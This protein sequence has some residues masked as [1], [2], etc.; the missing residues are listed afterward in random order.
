MF[1]FKLATSRQLASAFA[2]HRIP[3]RPSRSVS[4]KATLYYLAPLEEYK[5]TKPYHINIPAW[6]LPPGKQSNEISQP[7]RNI[8]ISGIR[9]NES[10]FKLDINGFAVVREEHRGHDSLYDC[11]SYEEYAD[12]HKVTTRV[13]PAVERFLKQLLGPQE[14]IAFSTQVRTYPLS[15]G[16]DLGASMRRSADAISNSLHF[17]EALMEIYLSQYKEFT[18]VSDAKGGSYSKSVT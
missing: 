7:Y 5:T 14:V 17:P 4:T 10:R 8:P 18:L 13:R 6:A 15:L 9:G 11:I 16:C 3:T 1:Q 2:L 12:P